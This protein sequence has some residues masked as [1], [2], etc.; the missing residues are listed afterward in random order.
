MFGLAISPLENRR[1]QISVIE[2]TEDQA[3]RPASLNFDR[4]DIVFL[5]Q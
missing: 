3:I 2:Q 5:E 4:A 1:G